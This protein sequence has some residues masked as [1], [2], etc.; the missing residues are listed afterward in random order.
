MSG[1]TTT[2]ICDTPEVGLVSWD[3][4]RISQ[5]PP[6]KSWEGSAF[7]SRANLQWAPVAAGPMDVAPS[8]GRS[9]LLP[10]LDEESAAMASERQVERFGPR[11]P[12]PAPLP[13]AQPRADA[14]QSPPNS[15]TLAQSIMWL[16]QRPATSPCVPSYRLCGVLAP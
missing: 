8:S 2:S 5:P 13:I 16:T 7:R 11:M 10:V 4:G 15:S 9:G 3:A 14:D 1:E 6:K 12:A